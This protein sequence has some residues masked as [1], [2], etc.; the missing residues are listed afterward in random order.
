MI[1][2]SQAATGSAEAGPDGDDEAGDDLDDPDGDHGL[3]GVAGDE[4]VDLGS[5][6][7]LPVHEPVEE[8]VEAEEDGGDGE[9]T[10]RRVKAW[11]VGS[12]SGCP[13]P[14]PGGR[15][16]VV[17]MEALLLKV[18]IVDHRDVARLRQ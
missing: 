14:E 16:R 9:R 4:V 15:R 18:N 2:L 11:K 10:R 5:E 8:L 7:D 1:P 12:S 6:V 13:V 17:A 3:V